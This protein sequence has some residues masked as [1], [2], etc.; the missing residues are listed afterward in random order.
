MLIKINSTRSDR[1][2][3]PKRTRDLAAKAEALAAEVAALHQ[4]NPYCQRGGPPGRLP[5]LY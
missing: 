3:L 2:D 1:N 4:D 5:M